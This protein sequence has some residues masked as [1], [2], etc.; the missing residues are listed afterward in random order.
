MKIRG[1]LI[2]SQ[3]RLKAIKMDGQLGFVRQREGRGGGLGPAVRGIW[4]GLRGGVDPAGSHG[5]QQVEQAQ[6]GFGAAQEL[7]ES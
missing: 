1:D 5:Q 7:R 4:G 2:Q 6:A 3:Y